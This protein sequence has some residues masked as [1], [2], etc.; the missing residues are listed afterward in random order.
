MCIPQLNLV[1]NTC[2]FKPFKLNLNQLMSRLLEY[3]NYVS[4][5]PLFI[6]DNIIGTIFHLTGTNKWSFYILAKGFSIHI[7]T[8][9]YLISF[10]IHFNR[11]S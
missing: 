6:Q 8:S 1:A 10:N 3:S 7:T 9:Y 2:S 5:V 4:L 11:Y